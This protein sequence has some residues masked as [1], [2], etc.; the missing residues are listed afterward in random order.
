MRRTLRRPAVAI[1]TL[2]A[3]SLTAAAALVAGRA[4]L[5]RDPPP[6]HRAERPGPYPSD[7]FGAQ[8]SWPL[9]R[10]PQD[11]YLAA[12]AHARVDRAAAGRGAPFGAQGTAALVWQQAGPYN[13]GGRVTALAVAPGGATV[14]L[15]SA[16]GGVF[17]SV[18]SGENWTPVFDATG[19]FSI[20]ALALHPS[21]P[22]TVLVG[23]GEANASVDSYDG[24]GVWRTTDGGATWASLGLEETRRIARVAYDPLNPQRIFVAAMGGQFSTGPHRGLYRSENGG[25]SWQQVLFVNDSTGVCDVVLN[26]AHPETMYCATWERIRRPSYRRAYGPA[27]GIW[28]SVDGGTSWT[29]LQTGLPAPSDSVGRIGLALAASSPSTVYA[30]VVGGANLGYNIL[31]LYRTTDAGA[32]WQRRDVPGGALSGMFGGFGWYFGDMAVDPTDPQRLFCLG[33][34]LQRSLDGGVSYSSATGQAHVD[35]HALWIDPAAPQRVY[36]GSDGGF[37]SSADGGNNWSKSEDLPITQFYAGT[38][39]P[40][41]PAVLY[42]GTQDNFTLKTTAGPSAWFPILGGDGFQVVVDPV[43]PNV[44]FAE[45]QFGCYGT[46]PRRSTNGGASFGA[47]ASGFV[48]S[49]RFNW[50]TPIEMNPGNHNVLL[51]GSHRVYRS[52]NNGLGYS[53]ISPDLT[54]APVAQ[55]VYGTITTLAISPADTSLY[56]AGTDDGQ[57]WRSMNRGGAWTNVSAALPDRYVTRVVADPADPDVVYVTL[58][59]FGL[60]EPLAH[61]YRSDDRGDTWSSISSNLPDIPANDLIVDP[62]DPQTLYLGTDVGV[63]ATRNG[64]AGWFPLGAGMPVQTIFDLTLHAPSRTLVAA[65]HGRSQW[66]LDLN[67]LPVAASPPAAPAGLALSGPA[68]NPARGAARFALELARPAR[69]TVTVYDAMGRRVRELAAGSMAAGRSE[70]AWDGRDAAG[71]RAGAGV[72]FVRAEAGG[73]VATARVVRVD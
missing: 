13:I 26:P 54:T 21:D 67:A 59:G 64:G 58:S 72:Y 71:R 25:A 3:V 55:V 28:K 73:E 20:G 39:D 41:N 44:V 42:G 17:K 52:T 68:P 29:R 6:P 63:Y 66:T 51:V 60:D 57:V 14:Y 18:N 36:A 16:N 34:S 65:T 33:V 70:I 5:H 8:R 15:G 48:S 53:T 30:Q 35:F 22:S 27:S 49:D 50:N 31:G 69:A 62:A 56:Y 12:L 47:A 32:T 43:N 4:F 2:A 9:D 45:Y 11:R 46:G 37:F 40:S 1:A 7:W 24:S 23:T 38:V 19:V 61:V 10:I